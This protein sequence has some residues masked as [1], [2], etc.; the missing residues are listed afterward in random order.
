[1]PYDVQVSPIAHLSG[2]L[3]GASEDISFETKWSRSMPV[4]NGMP[5]ETAKGYRSG[6]LDAYGNVPERQ[7]SDGGAPCRC[8]LRSVPEGEEMLVFA[9]RPFSV[10]Q[11]Y[12]ETGPVFLCAK[13]CAPSGAPGLPEILTSPDYLLKGYSSDERIIYGTG[14]ITPVE[15]VSS[16]ADALLNRHD[17][18]FVDL[19]SA[20]NNCW[21]A[22]L[23]SEQQ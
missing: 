13:P 12:A 23:T 2:R 18:A 8:C 14:R 21:Q 11:P 1:M 22:R 20:R 4:F 7:I 9:Y 6:T 3:V 10:L 5:I 17:V 15:E 16:Y 19:R